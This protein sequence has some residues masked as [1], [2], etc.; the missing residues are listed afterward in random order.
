MKLKEKHKS[1]SSPNSQLRFDAQRESVSRCRSDVT[2]CVLLQN[3]IFKIRAILDRRNVSQV[4]SSLELC[5][6]FG[7]FKDYKVVPI[8]SQ[9]KH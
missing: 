5:D 1:Q 8:V 6:P 3:I 4:L 2:S 9:K 7:F